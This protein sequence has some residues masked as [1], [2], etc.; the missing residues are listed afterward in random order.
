MTSPLHTDRHANLQVYISYST[1]SYSIFSLKTENSDEYKLHKHSVIKLEILLVSLNPMHDWNLQ[2]LLQTTNWKAIILNK[3]I[4]ID[5]IRLRSR[6]CSRL[7]RIQQWLRYLQVLEPSLLPVDFIS[8]NKAFLL[9]NTN[10]TNQQKQKMY[11]AI[12]VKKLSWHY[13]YCFVLSEH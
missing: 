2:L 12:C 4:Q 3:I 5:L 6:W 9:T 1:R 10:T 8:R 7:A 13:L 11:H